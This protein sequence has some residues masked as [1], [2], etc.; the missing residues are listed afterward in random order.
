[1]PL[2]CAVHHLVC[3]AQDMRDTKMGPVFTFARVGWLEYN[4][5]E[6]VTSGFCRTEHIEHIYKEG[7]IKGN[8]DCGNII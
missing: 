5:S 4:A 3:T 2:D 7:L 8:F 1:M 6:N